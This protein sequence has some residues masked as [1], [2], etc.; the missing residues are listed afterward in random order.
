MKHVGIIGPGLVGRAIAARLRAA[1]F[2][3]VGFDTDPRALA[4]F[5]G[6]KAV[7]TSHLRSIAVMSLQHRLRRNPLDDAG[8]STRVERA[9]AQLFGA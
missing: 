6:A 3:P 2:A 9:V 4:A 1:G 7:S 8:S 5:E